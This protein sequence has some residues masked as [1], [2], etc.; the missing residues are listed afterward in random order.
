MRVR[1]RSTA[2]TPNP[3]RPGLAGRLLV[4]GLFAIAFVVTGCGS[5]E[6]DPGP[7]EPVAPEFM[8]DPRFGVYVSGRIDAVLGTPLVILIE[9]AGDFQAEDVG[10]VTLDDGRALETELYWVG[11]RPGDPG[12]SWLVPSGEW[13]ARTVD[14]VMSGGVPRGEV[15]TW[16]LMIDPPIDAVG[17]GLWIAGQRRT[18][19]WL[20]DPAVVAS[21]VSSRAW[22]SPLAPVMR[23][24][25]KL[26]YIV[27]PERTSPFRRWRYKLMVGELSPVV[28]RR[29][30]EL[31]G[32]VRRPQREGDVEWA[33]GKLVSRVLETLAR[34]QESKWAIALARLDQ[35]DDELAEAVR[36]RLC[37][38]V[39]FG[40]GEIAPVWPV[41]QEGIA[42]LL[43][44]LL[45][46]QLAPRARARRARIWLEDQ[47]TSVAWVVSDAPRADG[48]TGQARTVIAAANMG[49]ESKLT[50][51]SSLVGGE[52]SDLSTLA[53]LTA[54]AY[55]ATS[56]VRTGE[57]PV[58]VARVG[59]EE[60]RLSVSG[61]SVVA[62][63]PGLRI[64]Q[65]AGDWTLAAML[66]GVPS[67]WPGGEAWRTGA[68]LY[69]EPAGRWILYVE[70]ATEDNASSQE[71]VRV[72]L[73]A[74][75]SP[76]DLVIELSPTREAFVETGEGV[77]SP[78]AVFA[79]EVEI[80]IF[81]SGWSARL[82]VP[83]RV[84]ESRGETLRLGLERRDALAR[85]SA[86][87]RAM[88][89][90]QGSCA[91]AAVD[92]SQW[93]GVGTR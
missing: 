76:S 22:L 13:T 12:T 82:V 59:D 73:G 50:S 55:E 30:V 60:H 39:D 15:G 10:P 66:A 62:T 9:L 47:P 90:W 35:A 68:L 36:R 84:I 29:I 20:P 28:E 25:S 79:P 78:V 16:A 83:E 43:S 3:I 44:D 74:E 58:V 14:E 1:R 38:V 11:V 23:E 91:R 33:T 85:R 93:G 54:R 18:V 88:L 34:Q 77:L 46:Q 49:Y 69:R 72:T 65:F 40:A 31:D 61:A 70:C 42:R 63:P 75:G 8:E 17:Q 26:R 48:P 71:R 87:P 81:P 24:S 86:W 2:T 6:P 4:A 37:A 52:S 57:T 64:D 53:P 80:S 67:A 56:R 32:S 21:R 5:S 89:P 92:L 19:N 7:W 27:E 45:D 51:V 41:Q